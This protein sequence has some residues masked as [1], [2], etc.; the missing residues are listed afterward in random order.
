MTH[1]INIKKHNFHIRIALDQHIEVTIISPR[2]T[3]TITARQ[4]SA[5]S[6][7]LLI[8]TMSPL[9]YIFIGQDIFRVC[10][11]T[12][13]VS[14]TNITGPFAVDIIGN[15]YLFEERVIIKNCPQCTDPCRYY[16]DNTMILGE[17]Q[18]ESLREEYLT[19]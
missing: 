14:F 1:T 7:A 12:P 11:L 10:T 6:G 4:V 19:L 13:L 2:G 9:I 3:F 15:Y 17:T 16:R 8:E 5:A 18:L